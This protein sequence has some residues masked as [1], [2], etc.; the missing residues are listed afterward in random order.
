MNLRSRTKNES[1]EPAAIPYTI[2]A[3]PA[4][5][6]AVI[7]ALANHHHD[8]LPPRPPRR[9]RRPLLSIGH[10]SSSTPRHPRRRCR[11]PL[12]SHEL[13]FQSPPRN[14][15]RF[16]AGHLGHR[17]GC[18]GRVRSHGQSRPHCGRIEGGIIDY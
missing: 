7:S 4:A 13:K 5:A 2:A 9:I 15:L 14:T 16:D 18:H 12:G 17:P 10:A 3:D 8:A 1:R 6:V 11:P